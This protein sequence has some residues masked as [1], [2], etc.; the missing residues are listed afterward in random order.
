MARNI[1]KTEIRR[2]GCMYAETLVHNPRIRPEDMPE[3]AD[4]P[5]WRT[6]KQDTQNNTIYNIRCI[7]RGQL[8]EAGY[9]HGTVV[10]VIG[11]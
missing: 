11:F 2:L 3:L 7:A 8:L 6:L 5:L 4:N 1:S 10:R 9:N